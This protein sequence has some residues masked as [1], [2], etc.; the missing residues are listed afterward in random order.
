MRSRVSPYLTVK[1]AAAAIDFYVKAFGAT[2]ELRLTEPSGRI[3]HAE[4]R[5]DDAL[6]MLADEY[7][8]YDILGPQS[9]GG[10]TVSL[11]LLVEDVDAFVAHAVQAGARLVREVKDEFYGERTGKLE[12]PFGHVWQ[13]ATRI[14]DVSAEEMQRRYDALLAG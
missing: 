3:G 11:A 4:V 8:E 13:V 1:N 6:I 10:T 5:F 14:E 12:D 2:E 9:R 7:P